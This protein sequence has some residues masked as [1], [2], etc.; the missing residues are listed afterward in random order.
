MYGW[1]CVRG[2]GRTPDTVVGEDDGWEAGYASSPAF[3]V[4]LPRSTCHPI[5]SFLCVRR[6]KQ[7]FVPLI[8][9][10]KRRGR[11]GAEFA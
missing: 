9:W 6:R 3:S 7:V 11:T 10:L 2:G 5:A 1:V 4:G 8:A